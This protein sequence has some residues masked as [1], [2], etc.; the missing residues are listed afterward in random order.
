M[1][2]RKAKQKQKKERKWEGFRTPGHMVQV[3]SRSHKDDPHWKGMVRVAQDWLDERS[4]P[5]TK[6]KRNDLLKIVNYTPHR[7][8]HTLMHD[9]SRARRGKHKGAG[10]WDAI[11]SLAQEARHLLGV[12][13]FMDSIGLGYEHKKLSTHQ[14]EAANAVSAA[15]KSIDKRPDRVGSM[16]RLPEY[17]TDGLAVFQQTNGQ[18]FVA[19][20]GTKLNKSDLFEDLQIM[21]GGE[22]RSTELQTLLQDLDNSGLKYDIAG[23]SLGTQYVQNAIEDG[24]GKGVDE[25]FLFNPA[26][27]P[28]QSDEYLKKM[29]NDEKY[30]YFIN[31]GDLVSKGIWQKMDSDT[32]DRVH[33]G[34]YR[35]DPV[36][37][38]FLDQ[39]GVLE[40]EKEEEGA[41][42]K[43]EDAEDEKEE[44]EEAEDAAEEQEEGEARVSGWTVN[45]NK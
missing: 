7:V 38:H 28:F 31:Q 4:V 11:K 8:A 26:S 20:R 21:G 15:Y 9:L 13:A 37:C 17:D 10:L 32:L 42:E 33:I 34:P 3:V 22:I 19:V 24:E 14:V 25:V 41:E 16:V 45:F 39:W 35:W 2:Y 1:R 27:S 6:V 29:A 5:T 23:H 40:P 30:Q 43:K 36:H 44:T 12:D 18:L